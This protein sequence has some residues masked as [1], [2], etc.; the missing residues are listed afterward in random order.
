LLQNSE[1]E[2]AES[3]ADE[4]EFTHD[5]NETLGVRAQSL[6]VAQCI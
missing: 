3:S 6:F 5:N 4:T 2:I 1:D